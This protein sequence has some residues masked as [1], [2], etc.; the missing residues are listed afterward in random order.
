MFSNIYEDMKNEDTGYCK[1]YGC[2]K[3]CF[4]VYL[5]HAVASKCSRRH[6]S[7]EKYKTRQSFKLHFPKNYPIVQLHASVSDYKR[8]GNIPE[9]YFMKAFSALPSHS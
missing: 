1:I 6:F 7:S 9:S 4:T 8:I 5:L 3:I 2:K